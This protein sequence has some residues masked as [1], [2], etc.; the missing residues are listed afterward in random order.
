VPRLKGRWRQTRVPPGFR[1]ELNRDEFLAKCFLDP[2]IQPAVA[3]AAGSGNNPW[4]Q[5]QW[6]PPRPPKFFVMILGRSRSRPGQYLMEPTEWWSALQSWVVRYDP[7]GPMPMLSV[8]EDL[9]ENYSSHI[10]VG[11]SR[12]GLREF[13]AQRRFGLRPERSRRMLNRALGIR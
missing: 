10:S 12:W 3:F 2:T 1:R 5:G 11:W 7:E 9:R 8:F 4:C 6:G 13:R